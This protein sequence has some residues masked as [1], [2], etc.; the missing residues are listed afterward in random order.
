[1]TTRLNFLSGPRQGDRRCEAVFLSHL[2]MKTIICR[3]RLGT[4]KTH[5]ENSKQEHR[6]VQPEGERSKQAAEERERFTT[7]VRKNALV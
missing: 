4:N 5:R 7:R 3:D 6:F 1:V 2:L